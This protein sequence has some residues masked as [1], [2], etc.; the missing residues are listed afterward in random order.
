M[1][2]FRSSQKSRPRLAA[3]AASRQGEI[4]RLAFQL[5][6]REAAMAFLN[7]DNAQL[8][9]RPLDLAT[10]DADGFARTS[11]ELTRHAAQVR[12]AG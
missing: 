6:G 5:L 3:D 1:M 10:A 9:A 8:G 7:N 11:A 2:N 12:D 4:A